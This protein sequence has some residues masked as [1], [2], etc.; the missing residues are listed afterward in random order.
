[1]FASVPVQ[2]RERATPFDGILEKS[3]DLICARLDDAIADMLDKAGDVYQ[4]GLG[5]GTDRLA[6]A[7]TDYN[8]DSSWTRVPS[9]H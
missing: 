8:P 5:P 9:G 3:R 6:R 2:E 7:M 4:K 1:M